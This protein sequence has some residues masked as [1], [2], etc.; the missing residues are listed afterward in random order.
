MDIWGYDGDENDDSNSQVSFHR[1]LMEYAEDGDDDSSL[2]SSGSTL[3]LDTHSHS[4]VLPSED[5]NTT[6]YVSADLPLS[7]YMNDDSPD[8]EFYSTGYVGS[9]RYVVP[10]HMISLVPGHRT[11]RIALMRTN[12]TVRETVVSVQSSLKQSQNI[13]SLSE[14][15]RW[16]VES[17][18]MNRFNPSCFE[19]TIDVWTDDMV[20]DAP[21][22]LGYEASVAQLA[23]ADLHIKQ[24]DG[25]YSVPVS[26]PTSR[27]RRPV[28]LGATLTVNNVVMMYP[29]INQYAVSSELRAPRD[30]HI[31][32]L[33][34]S[35]SSSSAAS[36][37]LIRY[38][39]SGTQCRTV[40][41]GIGDR[42]LELADILDELNTYEDDEDDD[43][44]DESQIVIG[45][46]TF[47][48]SSTAR[49]RLCQLMYSTLAY[50]PHCYTLHATDNP[51]RIIMS[52]SNGT[53]MKQDRNGM[54]IDNMMIS[55]ESEMRRLSYSDVISPQLLLIPFIEYINPTRASLLNIYLEQAVCKPSSVYESTMEMVP[56]YH[57]DVIL[58]SDN[59]AAN[60]RD[61]SHVIPGLNVFTIFMN[62]ELTY[63]D[64]MV[65]SESAAKRFGYRCY[66]HIRLAGRYHT[67]IS[68][69]QKI[70]P[71]EFAWW[72]C[73]DVGRI[74][75][76][77]SIPSGHIVATVMRECIAVNGDKFTT[78]HGQKGVITILPDEQMP[79]INGRCAE[80]I[81]SSASIIKR[82]TA[83]QIIEASCNQFW[84]EHGNTDADRKPTYSECLQLYSTVRRS[85]V[86]RSSDSTIN[87]ICGYY[88][89]DVYL[90]WNDGTKRTVKRK[91]M[92]MN[93]SIPSIENV[94]C[95]YGTIRVIQSVFMSSNRMSCTMQRCS[96]FSISPSSSSASG[97]S[98]SLGEME[99]LQLYGSGMKHVIQEFKDRSD[100]C[101]VKCC[102]SCMCLCIVCICDEDTDPFDCI[103]SS[104]SVTAI[105][106]MKV[107]RN[108][109]VHLLPDL[110]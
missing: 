18:N 4:T 83:S 97:G 24:S 16:I 59:I 64:A 107:T 96:R 100:S 99:L 106:A 25:I 78:L 90:P 58:I 98:K 40:R 95:N 37:G 43:N 14:Y 12:T 39:A 110:T 30:E 38:M 15:L 2:D 1:S 102:G 35:S 70:D 8:Y 74:V 79:S 48:I 33:C 6:R 51:D 45:T 36:K 50:T 81:I 41:A 105:V 52:I 13:K 104:S 93:S 92:S 86:A 53:V 61:N 88:E 10:L 46:R 71:F 103:L 77:N 68:V 76:I 73:F 49:S 89:S 44:N 5:L 60:Y 21:L 94:R 11:R 22:T 69:G 17:M 26:A 67:S 62:L 72:Q 28:G 75:R 47:I 34:C 63:E 31:G 27:Y 29:D 84:I 9:K 3:A 101:I 23:H 57:E 20:D 32:F 7:R 54:W 109:N 85:R 66:H 55:V 82:H 65:M 42:L 108:I 87:S 19:T 80:M 91:C 56:E